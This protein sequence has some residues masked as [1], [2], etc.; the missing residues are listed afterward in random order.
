[1]NILEESKH[2]RTVSNHGQTPSYSIY[3]T[4][5]LAK[6][7][8]LDGRSRYSKVYTVKMQADNNNKDNDNEDNNNNEDNDINDNDNEHNV[9]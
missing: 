9:K 5:S 1:M 4:A 2:F 7:F 3:Q 8:S 6:D